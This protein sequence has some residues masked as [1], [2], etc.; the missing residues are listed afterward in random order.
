MRSIPTTPRGYLVKIDLRKYRKGVVALAGVLVVL[1]GALTDGAVTADEV[2]DILI[3]I[4]VAC[5]VFAVPNS[6]PSE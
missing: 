2:T 6:T 5:G 1:G 3:A 4:G